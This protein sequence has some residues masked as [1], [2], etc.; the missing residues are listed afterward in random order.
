LPELADDLADAI[1]GEISV[2]VGGGDGGVHHILGEGFELGHIFGVFVAP[3]AVAVAQFV[4]GFVFD[5]AQGAQLAQVFIKYLGAVLDMFDGVGGGKG[6]FGMYGDGDVVDAGEP[7]GK[8]NFH[9][10]R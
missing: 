6:V 7:G 2:L 1:V 4:G 10:R 5:A 3:D 9:G 8:I